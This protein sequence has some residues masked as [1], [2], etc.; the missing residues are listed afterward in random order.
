[1]F[2]NILWFPQII[3]TSAN[4]SPYMLPLKGTKRVYLNIVV[5]N[6]Y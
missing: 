4:T 2:L 5:T 1:M 6:R 3:E